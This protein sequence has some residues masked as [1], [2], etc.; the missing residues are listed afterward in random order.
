MPV[1]DWAR[2]PPGAFHSFALGWLVAL[3]RSLNTGLLPAG[4]YADT[5]RTGLPGGWV[6]VPRDDGSSS[7]P[8]ARRFGAQVERVARPNRLRVGWA[9]DHSAVAYIEVV[10]PVNRNRPGAAR[11]F[12]RNAARSLRRGVHTLL[13]DILRPGSYDPRG[14][15]DAVWR[16]FDPEQPPYDPPPGRP[17][18]LAAY[19]A[20]PPRADADVV[21]LAFGDVMPDMPLYL[22]PGGAV[23][24]PLEATYAAA[25]DGT[26]DVWR[27]ELTG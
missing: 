6:G 23:A 22:E 18:T 10:S 26:P 5:E 8:G 16:A 11:A 2:V 4:F 19:S 17:L 1:H 7:V 13:V 3:K 20:D 24:V 27:E 9:A 25:W 21:G 15:H 12:G 14:M